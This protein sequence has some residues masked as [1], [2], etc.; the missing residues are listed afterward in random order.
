MAIEQLV[1][2]DV[3]RFV[4]AVAV[5]VLEDLD[6]P[7]RRLARRRAVRIVEHF[8]DE[9][10]AVLVERHRHRAFDL[11]LAGDQLDPQPRRDLETR[12]GP[13]PASATSFAAV[14]GLGG[15]D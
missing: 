15:D 7:L 10:S 2:E 4:P 8:D 13:A 3:A 1:G 11:R 14:V 5:A 9:Q 6:P 12:P